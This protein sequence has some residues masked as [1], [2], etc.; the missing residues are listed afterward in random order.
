MRRISLRIV[1]LYALFA[2]ISIATNLLVQRIMN[3]LYTGAYELYAGLAAGTLAGLLVKYVLDKKYI[4]NYMSTGFAADI[5]TF[6]LY[7]SMGVVT[8][9][10]FWG[11]EILFE[12]VFEAEPARYIGGGVGL[13]AGYAIKYLLDRRF[14]FRQ[15]E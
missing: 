15:A 3:L 8:T 4:F 13:T 14:V 5:K 10:V 11:T 7:S 2:G 1:V 6:I 9:A 12:L